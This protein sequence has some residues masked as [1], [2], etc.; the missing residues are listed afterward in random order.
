MKR[1][2]TGMGPESSAPLSAG[3]GGS[4]FHHIART[5][6]GGA[7]P[8]TGVDGT[9]TRSPGRGGGGGSRGGK[10]RASWIASV[11][12]RARDT[13]VQKVKVTMRMFQQQFD[14]I[15][16]SNDNDSAVDPQDHS[17]R[18]NYALLI[19]LYTLQGI[20]MGLS[21]SIPFLLQ[22]KIQKLTA[23][24]AATAGAAS[25][26]AAVG[27]AAAAGAISSDAASAAASEAARASYNANAIFSLCSWPFSLKLLWAPIV[28]A[29]YF[30]RFG[31]RKSWLV[32][33]QSAAGLIMI[34]GAQFV[35]NQL[36]LTSSGGET[37]SSS[38][39]MNVR[40]VTTFFFVLYFLMATQDIAVDGWAL[41]MLSKK[42]RGRGPI[43][44]SIGQNI[45][46]F[47][48]FVGFLALNDAESSETMWRPL[49]G[50]PSNPDHGLVTLKGFLRFMGSFML[51]TTA[52]VAIFKREMPSS[53]NNDADKNDA[54]GLLARF[55]NEDSTTTNAEGQE[56]DDDDA[57]LDASEIGLKET[58]HRL[59]AV[60][61]LPA[62]RWLFVILVTYRLPTALSDNVKFLKA[63]ENGLSKATTA[64]LSPT[65]ILPLGIM[66]PLVASKI[67][68][69]EPLRQFIRA[70]EWR[71]TVV[72]LLDIFMLTL[73]KSKYPHN[74]M[75]FWSA[76]IASTAGQAICNSLQFNAQMTFFAS[77]VDPAI[78]GSYMTLL[79]TMANLGGTWPASFIMSL[80]G[81][82]T[83]PEDSGAGMSHDPYTI[84]QA[85]LSI[86]GIAWIFT[87][88][89]KLRRL[90]ALPDDAWRTHLLDGTAKTVD[91]SSLGAVESGE[92]D[93]TRWM[94]AKND[95][96]IE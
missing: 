67:W 75:L 3:G 21:A 9:P 58:Y 43:C 83:H 53:K 12:T 28:D 59:W 37:L 11:A 60:C 10:A 76:V 19:V 89:P 7:T 84:V 1:R 68:H 95:G 71:V 54:V 22:E 44:N 90:A 16:S 80:L 27:S 65:L 61:K 32:P 46:Y 36:G 82:V 6:G 25:A 34:F 31:R 56:D 47:L 2:S 57:E 69:M 18:F 40:G 41:T 17:D 52:M 38:A 78:G 45:G 13:T 77:R 8:S 86:L 64:L 92:V 81:H 42:N 24:A 62:V 73:L 5:R 50:L 72:P 85:V 26:T 23:A 20:P 30:K 4:S 87:L 70:Y 94:N 88:G 55:K 91:E 96:K 33:V 51:M 39:S 66:V 74:T 48:S 14:N 35:E 93:V 49:L 79:N 15:S 29:V 63:T